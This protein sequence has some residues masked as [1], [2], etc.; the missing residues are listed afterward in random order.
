MTELRAL[1]HQQDG[2]APGMAWLD[3]PS[4]PPGS[5]LV[6]VIA[7][8]LD[9]DDLALLRDVDQARVG[10][11]FFVGAIEALG[12]GVT[13]DAAGHRLRPGT[14]VLAPSV[15]RCG[16]CALCREPPAH[17]IGCLA[18]IRLGVD[19]GIGLSGGLADA[20]FLPRA[21]LHALPLT[22]PPWVATLAELLATALLAC[23]RAQAIGRFAPGASVVVMGRDAL[24]LMLVIAAEALGAGRIVV[25]GE[26]DSAFLRLARLCGA[27]AT[28]DATEVTDPQERVAIIRET[29]G[30]RGA[31]LVLA[32][33]GVPTEGLAALREGGALVTLG[34]GPVAPGPL[35][36]AQLAVLGSDGFQ[37]AD[38]PVA[39]RLLHRARGRY[40]LAEMHPRF[41]FSVEGV[42]AG[43]AALDNGGIVR[44]LVV[45]RPD[46]A[47]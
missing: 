40:P 12:A 27:E 2:G 33:R 29:V 32:R 36:E 38:I 46:L 37:P 39:L 22:Q 11:R 1:V 20:V 10:G 47:G 16:A 28:I 43:L 21:A 42:A 23:A 25:L 9:H 7:T 30:G 17:A 26:P 15:L 41:P 45:H 18:P 8:A 31:D 24:S 44:A 6:S 5:A 34:P 35:S 4:L 14:P 19:P 3:R 13:E